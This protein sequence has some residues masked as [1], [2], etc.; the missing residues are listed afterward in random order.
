MIL[1]V[2]HFRF[3]HLTPHIMMFG[4]FTLQ[5]VT[6]RVFLFKTF[7]LS[8]FYFSL[9]L[10]CFYSLSLS[11]YNIIYIVSLFLSH[12]YFNTQVSRIK[13]LYLLYNLMVQINK[14]IYSANHKET[15]VHSRQQLGSS[16]LDLKHCLLPRTSTE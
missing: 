9:S 6:F 10:S 4:S 15:C 14:L 16:E 11:K 5:S 1:N 7:I 2:R 13:I 12:H 3:W 8:L